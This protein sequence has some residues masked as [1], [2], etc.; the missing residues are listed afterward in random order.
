[1]I[2]GFTYFK[3][4]STYKGLPKLK[5]KGFKIDKPAIKVSDLDLSV[6]AKQLDKSNFKLKI[7][8]GNAQ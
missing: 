1:M 4:R 3:S 5:S 7:Y 2:H 6:V 8:K